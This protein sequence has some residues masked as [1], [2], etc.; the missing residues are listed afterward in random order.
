[1]FLQKLE[2][3]GF[4]SF[5]RKTTLEFNQGI[6]SVVGPNGS[7][8][9]N[10]A[11]SI[12]WVMGE[13]S[14]KSLRGKKSIDVIF[15][16]SDKASRL[17]LAEVSLYFDNNDHL[18]PVDYSEIVISRKIY[19]DGHGE[20]FINHQP[21]RLQDI[22]MLL[23][24]INLSSKTYSVISQGMVD[25]ILSISPAERKDFFEEASG[26]K[27]LQMK[28]SESLRKLAATNENLQTLDIQL[29]EIQPRLRSLTRQVRR[30]DERVELENKLR[31]LQYHY[32]GE[33]FHNLSLQNK[34]FIENQEASAKNISRVDTKIKELQDRMHALTRESSHSDQFTQL[35]QDYQDVFAKKS[36]LKETEL[37]LRGKLLQSVK[38][39]ERSHVPAQVVKQVYTS[40]TKLKESFNELAASVPTSPEDREAWQRSF[41]VLA[42]RTDELFV[43]LKPYVDV[44]SS[45]GD[46]E[47]KIE[48]ISKELE[49]YDL[50]LVDIQQQITKLT[51][52]EKKEKDEIWETQNELQQHQR[53]LNQFMNE[54]NEIKVERA[55]VE[56]R[57]GD[58]STEIL[59][60]IGEDFYGLV[61]KWSP[62]NKPQQFDDIEQV[63]QKMHQLKHQLDL[64]GGI[65]PE[66]KKEHGEIKE[67]FE[68]LESQ[69]NDLRGTINNIQKV[70][71]EL[72]GTIKKQFNES[73]KHINAEFQKFFKMLFSGGRSE[74]RLIKG[75]A[76]IHSEDADDDDLDEDDEDMNTPAQQKKNDDE[77]IGV[78]ISATPPGKTEI[79]THAFW[80]RARTH[81]DRAYL[82]NH[83]KQPSAICSA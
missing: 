45:S 63:R 37:S 50:K 61:Q 30:L 22:L 52:E 64:V 38:Q 12:R 83:C 43:P 32:F 23:A 57:L 33:M 40:W 36:S 74:L 75:S 62:H 66:V 59:E 47:K 67:R 68:F 17:G 21:A 27:P 78:D 1:M 19:R 2:I 80:W 20:Y 41:S 15:S 49:Q 54:Q 14:L 46:L 31:D 55:R 69:S 51:Q 82:R 25:M 65:D 13:Q 53:E 39:S 56:T 8:K 24:Q 34:K 16:G 6:T 44:Q 76:P 26:V 77:I 72:D 79:N 73:F 71:E 35:Q 58:I 81:V 11:E 18:A 9:S 5:A 48:Q 10:I 70:I 3:N 4:K 7:G 28:K 29:Q 42:K 60:E